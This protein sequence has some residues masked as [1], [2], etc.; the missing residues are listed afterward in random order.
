MSHN[1]AIRKLA[2]KIYEKIVK[3]FFG[4]LIRKL[5]S[6]RGNVKQWIE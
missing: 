1:N 6:V 2:D 3:K 4:S 5:E